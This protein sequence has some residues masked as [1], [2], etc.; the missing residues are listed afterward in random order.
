VVNMRALLLPVYVPTLLLSFGQAIVVP[1]LPLYARAFGVS[2][3][4]ISLA[5]AAAGVGTMFADVPSGM[6]LERL[7]RRPM[8][9]MG[10]LLIGISAFGSLMAGTY[11][12]LVAFRVLGGMGSAFWGISRMAYL[13]DVVPLAQRGRAIASFGGINRIGAFS[14]PAIGGLLA[15]RFGL[16]SP[17]A[18]TA[19]TAIIAGVVSYLYVAESGRK[20]A[21]G[22]RGMRWN[23][24]ATVVQTHYKELFAAGSAQIFAQ[25]IR[26]GR[27][28]IVPLYGATVLGL[29]IGAVGAIVSLSAA[30]DM[31]LFIPAGVVM[32]RFGRKFAS[33]PSFVIMAIGMALVPLSYN[34]ASLAVA[35][36]VMGIGNG[37]GSGTMMTLGAD[38]APRKA[39][40]EFLGVWRL[41]GDVG[42]AGGPLVV[43]AIADIVGLG[44]AA[45]VLSGVGLFAALTLMLFVEETLNRPVSPVTE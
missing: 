42:S 11:G 18:C 19:V 12:V 22:H 36:M 28:I 13:T 39:T 32:D 30:V 16:A 37:M 41:I 9:L 43:G 3:S 33:V 40:G 44:L 24:V 21:A 34:F 26:A 7:G 8:M 4:L 20:A 35:T 27:Q 1:T 45:G 17:F 38:L 15:Q 5:V 10:C 29:D 25:M 23:V 14:G 2:F 6:M 31:A